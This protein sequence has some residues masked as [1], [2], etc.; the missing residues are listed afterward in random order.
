MLDVYS[1][2]YFLGF[3][4]D[5][6]S[7]ARCIRHEHDFAIIM[8]LKLLSELH[9]SYFYYAVMTDAKYARTR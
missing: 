9:S 6:G 5:L 7:V 3:P 4:D 2:T 1:V 8:N